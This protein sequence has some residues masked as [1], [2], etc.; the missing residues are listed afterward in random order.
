MADYLLEFKNISKVF[1]GVVALDDVSFGIEKGKITGLVGENGAGKSTLI[2]ICDGVHQ[3][4]KGQLIWAGEPVNI[5]SPAAAKKLGISVVHQDIPVCDNLTVAENIFLGP[6]IPGKNIFADRKYMEQKTLKL[7]SELNVEIDPGKLVK[8]CT[9]GEK[10]LILIAKAMS[11]KA[12][13]ILM[14]EPTTALSPNEVTILYKVLNKLKKEGVSIVFISHRLEEVQKLS[15][16]I[17]VL[18]DG[19]YVGDLTKK[20]ANEDII[21]QMM[22]GRD[23][24]ISQEYKENFS[25]E[26]EIFTVEGLQNK[27][28]GLENISFA[29]NKGE[30]LGIF[31]L[32]GAGR[33]EM[34]RSLIGDFESTAA[35]IK[36]ADKTVEIKSPK[37]AFAN[38]IGYLPEDRDELGLL[39]NMDIVENMCISDID[40]LTNMGFLQKRKMRKIAEEYQD[41]LDI[42]LSSIYQ[43]INELSGGNQQKVLLAKWLIL[44]PKVLILDEPT[45]GIDVGTKSEI[46]KLIIELTK[47][48]MSIIVI[49]SEMIELMS[50][51]D[52]MLVM[53]E[54]KLTADLSREEFDEELIMKKAVTELSI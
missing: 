28:Y 12:K 19:Q 33:T 40:Q 36:I 39:D 22:V 23:V 43:N 44:N 26:E 11:K 4:T 47:N 17:C 7:F 6:K 50:I 41:K 1:G 9:T 42:K 52:R 54:G 3:P 5:N 30:V 16:R 27:E 14:D 51:A 20:E 48:N 15:D 18:K 29:L 49:S 31:G 25:T 34:A 38:G 24:R 10:Q 2:K 8:R 32:R 45:K 53:S 35:K 46:R 21:C 13:L 37:D